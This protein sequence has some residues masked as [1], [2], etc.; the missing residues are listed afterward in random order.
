MCGGVEVQFH[1][2]QSQHYMELIGELYAP[3]PFTTREKAISVIGIEGCVVLAIGL[4]PMQ[5]KKPPVPVPSCTSSSTYQLS[6][7]NSAL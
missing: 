6:Y 7:H 3:S 2:S 4:D 5:I 1:A